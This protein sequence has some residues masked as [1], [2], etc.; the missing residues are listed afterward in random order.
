MDDFG[1]FVRQ[2][3]VVIVVLTII[4]IALRVIRSRKHYSWGQKFLAGGVLGTLLYIADGLREAISIDLEWR[5]RLVPLFFGL[6]CYACYITE[7]SALARK[8]W[9]K[10]PL[11]DK[12]DTL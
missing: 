10:D 9:G 7:P 2:I 5:W 3:A 6:V 4:F 12:D 8:R 1:V 11:K